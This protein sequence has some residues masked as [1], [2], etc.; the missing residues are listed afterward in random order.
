[1]RSQPERER[2]LPGIATHLPWNQAE[3]LG[4]EWAQDVRKSLG[5]ENRPACGGWPGTLSEARAR[6]AAIVSTWSAVSGRT[7]VTASEFESMAGAL[8]ASARN[9]WRTYAQPEKSIDNVE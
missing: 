6:L 4:S 2:V 3:A 9:T 7:T 5:F 8:Y 1:V